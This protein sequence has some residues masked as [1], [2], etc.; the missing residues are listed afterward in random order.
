MKW[1]SGYVFTV[2]RKRGPVW[3]AKY[4]TPHGR[5]V[6]KIIGPAWAGRDAAPPGS[7]TKRS[8]EA[9]LRTRLEEMTAESLL[10]WS[11]RARPLRMRRMSI[12]G[13]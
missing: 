7:Y 4:R 10:A 2:D 12:S 3:Y 1:G 6:Q 9:W 5:Q 8:A 11:R 13:S